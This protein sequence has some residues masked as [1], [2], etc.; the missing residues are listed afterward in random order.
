M[1]FVKTRLA[2]SLG[3][4][5]AHAIYI[6]LVETLL[7]RLDPIRF[8]ELRIAP[9]DALSECKIWHKSK[10][11]M[12]TQ[13]EGN[14]GE[15]LQRAFAEA[16]DEGWQKVIA[17]GSDCP[18]IGEREIIA[19]STALETCPIVLGPAI[20][21]G[22]WLIGTKHFFPHLFEGVDWSS[23]K[24]FDQTLQQAHK[25][26]L[27]VHLLDWLEDIDEETAWKRYLKRHCTI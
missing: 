3:N 27:N 26:G 22:Y 16:F 20:D 2:A 1:G 25:Q 12:K 15:R 11:T 19:A 10:W 14:L 21:G 13:G 8:V 17:I 9:D 4:Q 7:N 5:S 18:E 6:Q 23:E 24:V